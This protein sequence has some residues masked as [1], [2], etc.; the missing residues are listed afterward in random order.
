MLRIERYGAFF[1]HDI[2]RSHALVGM[3]P[4][5]LCVT[6]QKRNAERPWRRSHA[7]REERSSTAAA[8]RSF[9]RGVNER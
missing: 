7:E 6:L 8:T 9:P 1:V 3:Y 2:D 5:T 4:V